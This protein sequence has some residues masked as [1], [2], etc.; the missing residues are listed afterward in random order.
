MAATPDSLSLGNNAANIAATSPDKIGLAI[1]K[2]RRVPSLAPGSLS[3][4]EEMKK[5]SSGHHSN[6]AE[7]VRIWKARNFIDQHCAEELS[8]RSEEHTSELQSH[9]FIS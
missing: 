1:A 4:G 3:S 2:E 5:K 7:P 6:G 9:S 8:L